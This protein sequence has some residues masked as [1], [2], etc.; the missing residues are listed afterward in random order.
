VRFSASSF[1]DPPSRPGGRDGP[2]KDDVPRSTVQNPFRSDRRLS[3]RRCGSC[4]LPLS[5]VRCCLTPQGFVSLPGRGNRSYHFSSKDA[6]W[7]KQSVTP[8][9][10]ASAIWQSH[11]HIEDI[12]LFDDMHWPRDLPT[13]VVLI[14]LWYLDMRRKYSGGTAQVRG[15]VTLKITLGEQAQPHLLPLALALGCSFQ[16]PCQHDATFV[17]LQHLLLPGT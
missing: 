11:A 5:P 9:L 6:S 2:P 13:Q 7:S 10:W 14:L 16:K 3:R 4:H 12:S 15:F 8:V 17:Y 1:A